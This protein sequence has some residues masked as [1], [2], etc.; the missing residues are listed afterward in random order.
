MQVTTTRFGTVEVP[1]DGLVT[2]ADGLP[3]FGGQRTMALLGAGDIP[4][5]SPATEHQNLFWLQDVDDPN[6]AFLTI[7]PWAAYPDYDIEI[8]P[9]EIDHAEADDVCVLNVVT[10]RR[11]RGGMQM[12]ANLMAPIVIDTAR[13]TGRQLILD[14]PELPIQAPLAASSNDTGDQITC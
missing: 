10:V 1:D 13:R 14:D 11:E 7:V 9:A 12:T 6:L 8:D 3:G 2:F 5:T 4:G